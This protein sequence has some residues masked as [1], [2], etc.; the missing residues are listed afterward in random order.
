MGLINAGGGEWTM[1]PSSKR[2]RDERG[3]GIGDIAAL[4]GILVIVIFI[5]LVMIGWFSP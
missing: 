2:Y 1:H 3:G 5:L 4:C